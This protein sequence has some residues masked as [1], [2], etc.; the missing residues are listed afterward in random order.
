MRNWLILVA[1]KGMF[2]INAL[3]LALKWPGYDP[4]YLAFWMKAT[5]VAQQKTSL[6]SRRWIEFDHTERNFQ[7]NS[8]ICILNKVLIILDYVFLKICHEL[9]LEPT[10]SQIACPHVFLTLKPMKRNLG[11]VVAGS[12]KAKT[13][14][15]H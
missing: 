9:S 2:T 3:D 6:H 7:S 13:S 5:S 11:V 14:W 4:W 10:V 12:V 8:N 1:S 15:G